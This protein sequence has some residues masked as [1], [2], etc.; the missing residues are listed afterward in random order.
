MPRVVFTPH[1]QRHLD[2]PDR[3]VDGGTVREALQAVFAEN[4]PLRGY[5]FDD[6]HRLRQHVVVFIDGE[7]IRDRDGLS[8]PVTETSEIYVMQ[9]LSGG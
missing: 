7:A 3:Q 4:P 9:A 8:D 1:L 2:C 6:S 5:I